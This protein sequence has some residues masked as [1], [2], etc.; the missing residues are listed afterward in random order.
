MARCV[1]AVS[2]PQRVR[3]QESGVAYF[4]PSKVHVDTI[5]IAPWNRRNIGKL[6]EETYSAVFSVFAHEGKRFIS[7]APS[8]CEIGNIARVLLKHG[9][10][11][12]RSRS[13]SF[14][15]FFRESHKIKNKFLREKLVLSKN[16]NPLD[17]RQR[18]FSSNSIFN[19]FRKRVSAAIFR[20]DVISYYILIFFI[21]FVIEKVIP[22]TSEMSKSFP[23]FWI[24]SDSINYFDIFWIY[25]IEKLK[26]KKTELFRV[27]KWLQKLHSEYPDNKMS[28]RR[29]YCYR[30]SAF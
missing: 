4:I 19:I 18:N 24:D 20:T 29:I 26:N 1:A 7:E 23:P 3:E 27:P 15:F 17:S 11:E 25:I 10:F 22:T 30:I 6:R 13:L 5:L 21:I 12:F 28:S 9:M 16:K 2:K 14:Y 8:L